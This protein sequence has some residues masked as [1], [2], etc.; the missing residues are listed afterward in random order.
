MTP[1][2]KRQVRITHLQNLIDDPRPISID[3]HHAHK[4]PNAAQSASAHTVP[5]PPRNIRTTAQRRHLL[6]RRRINAP[7]HPRSILR[8]PLVEEEYNARRRI[9]ADREVRPSS[10]P[11]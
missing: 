5:Q 8:T 3:N 9:D 6:A 4:R 7:V 1:L 2:V 11:H 10:I